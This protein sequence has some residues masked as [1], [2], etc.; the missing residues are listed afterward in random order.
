MVAGHLFLGALLSCCFRRTPSCLVSKMSSQ[1]SCS[2]VHGLQPSDIVFPPSGLTAP[3]A[4]S[5]PDIFHVLL[6][7]LGHIHI[8]IHTLSEI[9]EAQA[10][11]WPCMSC[12]HFYPTDDPQQ[13]IQLPSLW[14]GHR[15]SPFSVSKLNRSSLCAS[16]RHT[17]IRKVASLGA[18]GGG[19]TSTL[20]PIVL[21]PLQLS[22]PHSG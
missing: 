22:L 4:C 2:P 5:L 9:Q 7:N 11:F 20:H 19:T 14:T 10:S 21:F 1:I 6:R 12:C 15:S 16:S 17:H 8:A 3:W 13:W 18:L